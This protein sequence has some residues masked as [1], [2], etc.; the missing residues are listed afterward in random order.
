MH[1]SKGS[2]DAPQHGDFIK[3]TKDMPWDRRGSQE[4]LLSHKFKVSAF[5]AS[6]SNAGASVNG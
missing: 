2:Q 3:E 1:A 4:L 5:E 6:A